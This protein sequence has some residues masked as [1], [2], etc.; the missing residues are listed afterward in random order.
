LGRHL[1]HRP[2]RNPWLTFGERLAKDLP[3]LLAGT[4]ESYHAYAFATVRQSGAAFEM[5]KSFVEWLAESDAGTAADALGRQV[6]GAK[7]LLMKLARRRAFDAAPAI[8]RLAED[9]EI[10]MNSLEGLSLGAVAV[11]S[12]R[13]VA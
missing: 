6:D 5:T 8:Q 3:E 13:G 2:R 11:G 4:D 10:A 1:T 7:A 12:Q 9:W